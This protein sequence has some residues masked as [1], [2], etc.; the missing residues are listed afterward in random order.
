MNTAI[1]FST[2]PQK[3]SL[4]KQ[5]AFLKNC[6]TRPSF[7]NLVGV[8]RSS[9]KHTRA[10]NLSRMADDIKKCVSTV[11]YF[12]NKATWSIRN[13]RHSL[14]TRLLT[15]KFTKIEEGDIATIDESSISK[16]GETFQFVGETWDNAE[17]EK[18]DGYTLMACAIVSTKKK[19]RFVFDEIL[20]SNS[21]PAFKSMPRYVLW[22]LRRL[23]QWTSILTVVFDCG[24]RN[25]YVIEYILKNK[26]NFIIRAT[27]DMVVWD[28]MKEQRS[29]FVNIKKMK[30]SHH[31]GFVVNKQR[32][33]SVTWYAGIINAWNALVKTPLTVLVIRRPSFRR[34]MILV[35]NLEVTDEQDALSI[36]ETY[37]NRW[38][39]EILFQDIKALG[40]ETFRVR[41]KRAIAKYVTVV[42][43]LHS[44]LTLQLAWARSVQRFSVSVQILLKAK[45]KITE[46]LFGGIKILYEMLLNGV[47][48]TRD[49]KSFVT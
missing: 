12:F 38:K 3:L 16:K 4:R 30:G 46:L 7:E 13:V 29:E 26:K 8:V 33:W 24:F 31:Q 45:R 34:P 6:F 17:K 21:D 1:S 15:S 2:I 37:L 19:I 22:L 39:I 23:F 20:Y 49:L 9:L 40:L 44:L 28:E 11:S 36:Y 48:T 27:T 14:R 18:H 25:Q 41:S 43:L 47:I 10:G 32:G 35:T 5:L 42:I